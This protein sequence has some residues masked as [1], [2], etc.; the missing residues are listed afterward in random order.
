MKESWGKDFGR[1]RTWW[2]IEMVNFDDSNWNMVLSQALIYPMG[3]PS[4][5][6]LTRS[7]LKPHVFNKGTASYRS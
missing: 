5:M 7:V 3:H 2:E 4:P 6:F 1:Y